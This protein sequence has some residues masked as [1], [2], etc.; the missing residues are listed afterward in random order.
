MQ[1]FH[2]NWFYSDV[3]FLLRQC[4]P[5]AFVLLRDYFNSFIFYRNGELPRNQ[6]TRSGVQVKKENEKLTALCSRSPHLVISLF[7]FAENGKEMY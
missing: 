4:G 7:C 5:Q 3:T 6:I 1:H 2:H